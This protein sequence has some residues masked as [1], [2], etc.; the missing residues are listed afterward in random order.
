MVPVT[1][2]DFAALDVNAFVVPDRLKFA[3]N[4][5]IE[6]FGLGNSQERLQLRPRADSPGNFLRMA[7][8]RYGYQLF[9]VVSGNWGCFWSLLLLHV[10]LFGLHRI[11]SPLFS[12]A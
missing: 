9:A 11:Y 7:V 10:G 8:N 3:V 1:D 2:E 5:F 6:H 4:Y 12:A